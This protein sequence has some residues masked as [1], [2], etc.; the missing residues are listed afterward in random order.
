MPSAEVQNRIDSLTADARDSVLTDIKRRISD[1]LTEVTWLNAR[2]SAGLAS[3]SFLTAVTGLQSAVAARPPVGTLAMLA[4][5][6]TV[7][8]LLAYA[9]VVVAAI[10]AYWI[11]DFPTGLDPDSMVTQYVPQPGQQLPPPPG[12]G[13]PPKV[14]DLIRRRLASSLI[15][16]FDQNSESLRSK[17][18]WTWR[19]L[20]GLALEALLLGVIT[21]IQLALPR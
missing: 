2:A 1:Q 4:Q 17:E 8:A 7:V 9:L 12:G 13:Q 10:F 3:G 15:D 5:A 14:V 20:F 21:T 18:T 16:A 6:L 19:V 11:R